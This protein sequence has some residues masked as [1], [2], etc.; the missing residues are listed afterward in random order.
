M[1]IPMSRSHVQVAGVENK[2]LGDYIKEVVE[3]LNTKEMK[4]DKP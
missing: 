4:G 3:M 1:L 2:K